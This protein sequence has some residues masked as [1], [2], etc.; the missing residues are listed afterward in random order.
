M[1]NRRATRS[2]QGMGSIRQRPDGKWEARYTVGRHPGTGKQMR[3]SI[4]GDTQQEVRKKLQQ[5]THDINKGVYTAPSRMTVSLWL[6]IWLK[7]YNR[8]VIPS[9]IVAYESNINNHLKPAIGATKLQALKPPAIQ[10]M[11]NDLSDKGLS[12]K[13][14][15][16]VHGV[17]NKAI[18][19]AVKLGYITMNPLIA[20][21]LPRM[22]KTKI[23]P[24]DKQEMYIF[25]EAIEGHKLE[26][27]LKTALFTGMR[28][29]EIMGLTW[30][31]VDFEK[32]IITV[33]RQLLRPRKKGDTFRFGPLKNDKP[34][35]LKPA[36]FV[37]DVLSNHRQAELEKRFQ[38]GNMWANSPNYV[39]TGTFG[40][41]AS[42]W[43]IN[44][45]LKRIFERVGI[46]SRHFHELR[47]TYAVTS[48]R[49]GDDIKT[50]QEN[51]GHHTAAFTLDVYGHV[52]DEMRQTSADRM[53]AFI[54]DLKRA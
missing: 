47:H 44:N 31:R 30:D 21:D 39:F 12:P 4:Y 3:R 19:Q 33:D 2:A 15:K 18:N 13:T 45:N 11:I 36:P 32:G 27:L 8:S 20:C 23:Y 52:T 22:E 54:D 35:T 16:N 51:L 26:A 5:V 43:E 6:D 14:V 50:V 34:R 17:L 46:G 24:L 28:L 41:H 10:Q 53:Q 29:G 49:A 9:T 37:M 48:L 1:S 40:G 7:E 25:L 42:Y 38:V